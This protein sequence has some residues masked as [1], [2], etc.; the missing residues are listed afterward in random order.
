MWAIAQFSLL[1]MRESAFYMLMIVAAVI[2]LFTNSADPVTEQVARGS[3]FSYAF[4]GSSGAPSIAMGSCVALIISIL[5]SSFYGSSE[6]PSDIS[7]GVILIILSKPVGRLRYL[8]G[9]YTAIVI[10]AYAIFIFL[11]LV[12]FASSKFF[13]FGVIPYNSMEMAFR[14]LVPALILLPLIAANIAFSIVTGALGAMIFTALYL[15]F[16]VVMAFLPLAMS[17]F[18]DGMIPFADM[19]L[20][21]V[22]YMFLNPLFYFHDMAVGTEPLI[23]LICYSVSVT[24][25]FLLLSVYM[26]F[27]TDLNTNTR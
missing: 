24:A 6:I 4:S 11:Q 7:S 9:K 20:F 14:Q 2:C 8:A 22:H 15:I 16:C 21:A 25:L 19:L 26:L 1:K 3:L 18:P 10:M 23:A 27:T 12:L 5:I 17:L 13:G